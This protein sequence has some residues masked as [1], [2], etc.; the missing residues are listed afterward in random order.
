VTNVWTLELGSLADGERFI[1]DSARAISPE[2]GLDA[3]EEIRRAHYDDPEN[4][5]RLE[6]VFVLFTGSRREV[7]GSGSVRLGDTG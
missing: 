1:R 2:E 5:P 6:R 4:P 3:L 7:C